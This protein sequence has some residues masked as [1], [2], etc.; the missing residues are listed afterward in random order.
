MS[1][2][3]PMDCSTELSTLM[4]KFT[5]HFVDFFEINL[6][7]TVLLFK[8]LLEKSK[9]EK[10]TFNINHNILHNPKLYLKNSYE[11]LDKLLADYGIKY[12][13]SSSDDELL[14]MIQK[15][16]SN[17]Q[18]SI[19]MRKILIK[20]CLLTCQKFEEALLNVQT[21]HIKILAKNAAN[22]VLKFYL[23]NKSSEF[24]SDLIY[25]AITAVTAV[26]SVLNKSVIELSWSDLFEN[27]MG[28]FYNTAPE[29]ILKVELKSGKSVHIHEIWNKLDLDSSVPILEKTESTILQYLKERDDDVLEKEFKILIPDCKNNLKFEMKNMTKCYHLE[30][31]EQISE[32][33]N[34]LEQIID[35]PEEEIEEKESKGSQPSGSK[36]I[37]IKGNKMNTWNTTFN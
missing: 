32:V 1:G 26:D 4:E 25:G 29:N 19:L 3:T 9:P 21:E 27:L 18:K 35:K 11:K 30:I 37:N 8:D 10:T 34:N 28:K 13:K 20:G 5:E 6:A 12:P 36:N 15:F 14:H 23:L 33:M 17:K 2:T 7:V 31:Y 22:R 24:D 16:N